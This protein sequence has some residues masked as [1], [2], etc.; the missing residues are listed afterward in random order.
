MFLRWLLL[1][2]VTLLGALPAWILPGWEGTEGRRAQIALEMLRSGEWMVPTLGGQP[3]WA[4]PP[5]HYWLLGAVFDGLGCQPWVARLPAVLLTFAS[6]VVAMELLR[7]WF[8][9]AA[10]WAAALGIALSPLV[11][12]EWPSAEIDPAFACFTAMSLWTLATGVAR[13]RVPLVLASGV[14]GGLALLQKGPPF[15]LFAAG[16]YLVWWRHRRLRFAAAHFVPMLA[17]VA[18]YFVPLWLWFVAPAEMLGVAR[19]E[20]VGR[21]AYFEWG[22]VL[23]VPGFWL[24]AVAV[25]VP[26]VF[27]CFWEWRGPR[28][29]RMDAGDLTLRMCSGA[30]VVAV[31]LLTF[32]P[33]RPTRYLLPNVLLFTFAVAPAVAQYAGQTGALGPLA[34]R[35]VWSM[36]LV[37]AITL[38]ALPFTPIAGPAPLAFAAAVGIGALWVRRP[39]HVVA[40]ALAIPLVA[41]WTLGLAR[42]WSWPE[43]RRAQ[44]PA[45]PVLR[46]ALDGLAATPALGMHGHVEA[47]L[48]LSAGILPPGDESGRREPTAAWLIAETRDGRSPLPPDY[49]ERLRLCLPTKT[50]VVAQRTASRR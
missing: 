12:S 43:H 37:A 11:L 31:L 30:A 10:A 25:Q 13:E 33:G 20:S 21:I 50:F 17:L 8:G 46:R 44:E 32:F 22:H 40:F 3:T 38:L 19:E 4:K 48:L 6:T 15:F 34:R 47:P 35:V 27:W 26:F 39:L 16:A 9:R 28:S 45:G 23:A 42:A 14:L 18:A 41:A 5:L 36:G 29:A 24:R 49:A 1:L 7:P 2:G